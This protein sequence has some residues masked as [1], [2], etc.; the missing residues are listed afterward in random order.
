MRFSVSRRAVLA[1]ALLLA[2]GSFTAVGGY[3]TFTGSSSVAQSI[4][5]GTLT[6]ELGAG[7]TTANRVTVPATAVAPGDTI[8]RAI[9]LW[10]GGSVGAASAALTIEATTSSL[11]DSDTTDGLQLVI[12]RCSVA[13]TESEPE[14]GVYTYACPGSVSTVLAST[15][16]IVADAALG[17]LDLD[18]AVNHLRVTLALPATAGNEF[19]GLSS[20]VEYTFT[21]VQRPGTSR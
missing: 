2:A 20:T 1:G 12:E 10:T 5:S 17:T 21:A 18:G 15:P 6:V 19:Q 3:A 11:L 9:D 8:E 7:G 16:V 14:A 13:W 4:G